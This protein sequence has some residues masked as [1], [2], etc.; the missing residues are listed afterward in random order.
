MLFCPRCADIRIPGVT[1][2][3]Y[4]AAIWLIAGGSAIVFDRTVGIGAVM[5]AII[6]TVFAIF[7]L[8]RFSAAP[9]YLGYRLS[10]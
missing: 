9:R 10:V 3:A 1:F 7:W 4:L 5:L 6:H 2:F 8:P